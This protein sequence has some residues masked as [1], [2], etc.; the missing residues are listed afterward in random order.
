MSIFL[1]PFIQAPISK[2]QNKLESKVFTP[3]TTPFFKG[4]EAMLSK[5]VRIFVFS[6][7]SLSKNAHVSKNIKNYKI[8]NI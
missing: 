6:A 3:Q 5:N 2:H 8:K 1:A 4:F 7:P